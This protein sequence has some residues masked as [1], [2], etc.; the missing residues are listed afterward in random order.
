[1]LLSKLYRGALEP[2][3]DLP[4]LKQLGRAWIQA[5]IF[6]AWNMGSFTVDSNK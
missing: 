6:L 1:M 2:L 4:A 3:S 5:Q